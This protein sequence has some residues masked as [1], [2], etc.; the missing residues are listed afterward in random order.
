VHK[1]EGDNGLLY[2]AV[3]YNDFPEWLVKQKDIN[4][5]AML[6]SGRDG[7]VAD[8]NGKVIMESKITLGNYPGR[9]VVIEAKGQFKTAIIKVR[10]YVVRNRMYQVM[11]I[12]AKGEGGSFERDN[13][14]DS[15]RLVER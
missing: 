2:C 4:W 7:L 13:F 12:T 1:F 3:I 8:T 15:F 11:V 6:D 5:D 9:E 10:I 14:M